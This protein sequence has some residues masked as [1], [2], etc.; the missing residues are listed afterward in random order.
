MDRVIADK[1]KIEG[2]VVLPASKS[3]SNR[4]LVLCALA[5]CP[6]PENLSD[7]DDTRVLRE[8]L[9]TS[10]RLVNVGHAGT[11]MRFLTAYFALKGGVRELTG[12]ERMKQR[13]VQVL[14]DAL[15]DLG[16]S[17]AYMGEEGFPPLWITSVPLQGGCSLVLD[18]SVSSQYVSALM[19]IAPLLPGGLTLALEER[20]VSAAYIRMT[21]SMM[22]L[23]G[24]D[25]RLEGGK[26]VVPE[27]GYIPVNLRV[28]S[29]WTAASYFYEVLS[30]VGQ[31]EIFIS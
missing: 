2:V 7:S 18:A 23:F 30:I 15:R 31:G 27:E 5:G 1:T 4:A 12:S 3:I 29:D 24:V 16:A 6:V 19:M 14:V 20:I 22:R 28:E 21:A 25:V 26:I 9:S 11:A 8:A 13:P 17:I 10:D